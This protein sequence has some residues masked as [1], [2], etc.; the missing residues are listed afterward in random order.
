MQVE[1]WV[2]F[3]DVPEERANE[4]GWMGGFFSNG[5]R[6]KDYIENFD[7][8]AVPYL[9]AVRADIIANARRFSGDAHQH[10]PGGVPVFSDG[11]FMR[12]SFRA[13]G[14]LMAAVWSEQENKDY[15]YMDFYM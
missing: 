10:Q 8:E 11:K 4:L 13:W 12:L 14:D 15:N 5:N 3:D 9:E 7:G 6:W 2:D 1:N